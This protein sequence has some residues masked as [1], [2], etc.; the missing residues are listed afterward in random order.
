MKLRLVLACAALGVASAA[1]AAPA[2]AA[3]PTVF[4]RF[5]KDRKA[6]P[7]PAKAPAKKAAKAAKDKQ[8][9]PE[10]PAALPKTI[11]L[12]PKGLKWGMSL[13]QV[14]LLYEKVIDKDCAKLFKGVNPGGPRY[15]A[16][17]VECADRKQVLRRSRIEFGTTPTG[18]D[19][20]PLRPEYT[21]GNGE[22]MTRLQLPNGTVRNFFFMQD[23]LW[24]VYDEYKLRKG[25]PLGATFKDA[26]EILT[27]KLGVPP[28]MRVADPDKGLDYDTADWQDSV[29]LIRAQDRGNVVALVYIEIATE[30][31]LPNLRT[32]KPEDAAAIDP[33]V[34]GATTPKKEPEPPSAKS[35]K[36]PA[37]KKK[38]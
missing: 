32:A 13:E 19:N 9:E 5:D 23:K 1:L 24:K 26:I 34:L 38:P 29:N 35:G 20:T 11:G 36:A 28:R 27:K 12:A 37:K 25:G 6:K 31:A 33:A 30:N 4:G 8:A 17:E 10:G 2:L 14:A 7:A 15:T 3:T 18:I 16:I 21:Y 22:S